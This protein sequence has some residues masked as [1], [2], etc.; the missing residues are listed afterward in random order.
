[1]E[2]KIC[3]KCKDTKPLNLYGKDKRRKD[4]LRSECN[5]CRKLDSKKYREKNPEKRKKTLIKYY[6]NNRE[7]ELN[8]LKK[9]RE[10]NPEKRKE[11]KKKWVEKNRDNYNAYLKGWKKNKFKNDIL[12]RLISNLRS[13]TKDFLVNNKQIKFNVIIGCDNLFLKEHLESLFLSGMTWDNYGF[14]GWHIDHIIPLSSAKTEDEL[15]KLCHYTNLQ[16]LWSIDNLKK[17][18][19]IL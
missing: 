5:E 3:S 11:T 13:R 14:Y 1:M 4:G 18:N 8:R 2:N 6:T 12:F 17:G 10:E 15:Y 7:K 9:Y 19:K 16:P